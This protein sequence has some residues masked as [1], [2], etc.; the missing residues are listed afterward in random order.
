MG[1]EKVGDAFR[2]AH[3]SKPTIF[4]TT[5]MIPGALRLL[6]VMLVLDLA[7]YATKSAFI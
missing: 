6:Q 1:Q 2:V 3:K 7:D 5:V 4:K